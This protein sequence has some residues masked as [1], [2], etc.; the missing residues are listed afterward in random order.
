MPGVSACVRVGLLTC[1]P[2]WC[3]G[4]AIRAPICLLPC[5]PLE[6]RVVDR[7]CAAGLGR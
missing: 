5:P 6:S 4:W 7:L 3:L 1:I 2:T